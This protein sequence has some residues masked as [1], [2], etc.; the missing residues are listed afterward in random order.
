MQWST[1]Q[2]HALTAV[3]SWLRAGDR[4]VFRL[5][6]YAGTGKTTLARHIAEAADGPVVFA[7]FTGKAAHVMRGKGCTDAGT[8]HSLIYRMRGEDETG[9]S[10]A[11]NRESPAAKAAM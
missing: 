8:I 4:P 11:L 9:P 3:E 10:F 7:A 6:G 5:F 1:Q 2:A